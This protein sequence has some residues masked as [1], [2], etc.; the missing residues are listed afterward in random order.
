MSKPQRAPGSADLGSASPGAPRVVGGGPG[1]GGPTTVY[2]SVDPSPDSYAE[3]HQ[4]AS[5]AGVPLEDIVPPEAASGTGDANASDVKGPSSKARDQPI[6]RILV[7]AGRISA[8]DAQ[9]VAQV[10][11]EFKMRF[12]DAA[13]EMEL[14]KRSD[15]DYALGRQFSFPHLDRNDPALSPD[16]IAAYQPDHPL[17]ERL[18]DLRSQIAARAI[19]GARAHP[20]VALLSADRGDG[21]SFIAANLAVAFAQMGQR[22]LIIDADMRN[23]TQHRLFRL[24]NRLGLSTL[25]SGRCGVECLHRV[26]SFPRIFVLTSGPTPPNP[27]ELLEKPVFAQLLASADVNF[28]AVIIDTPAG[29]IA[30]DARLIGNRAGAGVLIARSGHT[31][32]QHG[33]RFI[34]TLKADQANVLG[35]VLNEQ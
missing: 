32:T 16:L 13:V 7:E 1:S 23:P 15:I 24:E 17:V 12:G 11:A 30:A 25:L 19:T 10:A 8:T 34:Q 35:V 22:T 6:G 26:E 4:G 9:R 14:V 29:V 31:R 18:R 3:A 27:L 33:E 21:R 5:R 20:V 28:K 2:P